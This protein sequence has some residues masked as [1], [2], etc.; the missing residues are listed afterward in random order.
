MDSIGW[1]GLIL[2]IILTIIIILSNILDKHIDTSVYY[3]TVIF[4]IIPLVNY[5]ID[6][7]R[8]YDALNLS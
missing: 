5:G 1:A 6:R 7:Y 4:Y 3:F 2:A 8:E